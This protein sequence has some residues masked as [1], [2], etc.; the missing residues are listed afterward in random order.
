MS[1]PPSY[2]AY[3]QQKKNIYEQADEKMN[4]YLGKSKWTQPRKE[5]LGTCPSLSVF[6]DSVATEKAKVI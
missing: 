5:A 4:D 2:A 3:Q 6:N 1:G